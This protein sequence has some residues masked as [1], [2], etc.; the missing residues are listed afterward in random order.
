MRLLTRRLNPE[1]PKPTYTTSR[2]NWE[3][4][5]NPKTHPRRLSR[6]VGT[7]FGPRA[8]PFKL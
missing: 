6:D 1:E 5:L 4:R 2:E 8:K 3:L 7:A